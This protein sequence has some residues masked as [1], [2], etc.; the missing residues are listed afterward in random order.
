LWGFFACTKP[1]EYTFRDVELV[2][3]WNIYP[4]STVLGKRQEF[5]ITGKNLY[6]AEVITGQSV[7]V[8]GK[9]ASADGVS[10]KMYLIVDTL[11]AT[12]PL[13]KPGERIIK[14]RNLETMKE[15]VIK[16]R[17]EKKKD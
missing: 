17:D 3:D 9:K 8:E 6:S 2:K 5:V 14:V 10:I 13:D 15:L 12:E 1:K 11:D 16:V 7:T 4:S